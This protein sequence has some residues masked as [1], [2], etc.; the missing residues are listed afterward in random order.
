MNFGAPVAPAPMGNDVVNLSKGEV[1]NLSKIVPTLKNAM[2]GLGW[3][4]NDSTGDSY[5]LD[6]EAFLC[7]AN[8]L[9]KPANF[10]F[11]NNLI[12]S[13][14]SVKHMGDNLTGG[15][16]GDCEQIFVNLKELPDDI[17]KV[18]F[19]V[20]IHLAEQRRQSFGQVQNAFIRLVD[21]D[22]N[23]EV[24]RYNLTEDY[25]VETALIVAEICR[26]SNGWEFKAV[27]TGF[28][29]GLQALC[30]HFGINAQHKQG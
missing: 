20:T 11:Y 12:N 23:E 15:G 3:D 6:A 29:N 4:E 30:S 14:G 19:T 13:N 7:G 22:T 2:I 8:D 28:S 16:D 18:V 25:S 27:G 24:V 9:C 5:D 26:G 10:I 21:L 1:V 17:S